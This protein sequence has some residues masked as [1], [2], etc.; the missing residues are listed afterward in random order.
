MDDLQKV[1][2]RINDNKKKQKTIREAYRDALV[3]NGEYQNL[4]EEL[5]QMK[6]KK[7]EIE[8]ETKREMGSN[9][10]KIEVIKFDIRMDNELMSDMALASLINGQKVEVNDEYDNKYIPLFSVKFK[11]D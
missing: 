6:N 7:K 3:N 9:Y 8:E 1:F 5:D 10:D 2:N 4:S 11:K